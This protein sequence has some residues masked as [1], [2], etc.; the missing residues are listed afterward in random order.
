MKISLMR[1]KKVDKRGLGAGEESSRLLPRIE[2]RHSSRA[3]DTE[4]KV[5]PEPF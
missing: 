1:T 2:M 3:A 4:E 5:N